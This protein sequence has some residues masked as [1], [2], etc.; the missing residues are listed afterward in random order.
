MIASR[1]RLTGLNGVYNERTVT[2]DGQRCG[3]RALTQRIQMRRGR[4]VA[5]KGEW[6]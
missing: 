6:I 1:F 3:E 4:N 5:D 2:H